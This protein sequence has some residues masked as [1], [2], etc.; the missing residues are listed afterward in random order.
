M[1]V[2]QGVV[3]ILETTLGEQWERGSQICQIADV[4]SH[5]D[6]GHRLIVGETS[7]GQLQ[8]HQLVAFLEICRRFDHQ[9]FAGGVH[10]IGMVDTRRSQGDDGRSDRQTQIGG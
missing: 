9:G 7:E 3:A 4:E 6:G 5:I 10:R 8:N 1:G 2:I